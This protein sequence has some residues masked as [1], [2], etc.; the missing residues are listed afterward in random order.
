M[1]Q[2]SR[3]Q[4]VAGGVVA[5]T[6]AALGL[7]GCTSKAAS[8]SGES[9]ATAQS[10]TG[11][12]WD[13]AP[14]PIADSQISETIES[15]VVI[16]GAGWSGIMTAL[17]ATEMGL[18]V[19]IVEKR[20]TFTAR[21]GSIHAAYSKEMEAAG[22]ER[23][24][25]G[26]TMKYDFGRYDY[27]INQQLWMRWWRN[28]EE[29]MNWLIDIMAKHGMKPAI[30]ACS[31]DPVDGSNTMRTGSHAFCVDDFDLSST[32]FCVYEKQYGNGVMVPFLVQ[33]IES[34]GGVFY[35]ENTAQ[36]LEKDDSGRVVTVVAQKADGS[37]VRY[38]GKK[39]I[40]LASG[41][42]SANREMMERYCDW[43][44]PFL[45][46]N[47]AYANGIDDGQGHKM[48]LWAGGTWQPGERS[49][50]NIVQ[51]GFE[52]LYSG[53]QAYRC[54][55]GLM[56]N[57]LGQ[58]FMNEDANHSDVAAAQMYQPGYNIWPIWSDAWADVKI[59]APHKFA[60]MFVEQPELDSSFDR[61]MWEQAVTDGTLI[62]AD[63]IEEL[64]DA[65]GLPK[66][67]TLKTIERYNELCHAGKDEDFFKSSIY[68]CPIEEGPFYT[69]PNPVSTPMFYTVMGGINVNDHNQVTDKDG[70]AI[71]GLY[72][73]GI[74]IAGMFSGLYN[75]HIPGH[76]LGQ[77]LTTGYLLGRDLAN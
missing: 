30:D 58:R 25:D 50:A 21:G 61:S 8:D 59:D 33:D 53:K 45:D 76:N 27:N 43:A 70:K 18:S 14:D 42:F 31:V 16:V 68:L 47:S 26:S 40:V 54:H 72:A 73:I 51:W 46:A 32:D 22:V 77:S 39:G 19:S 12:S 63:T 38:S 7:A 44:I 60:P 35:Y 6:V 67:E 34:A 69:T 13:T 24:D 5:S 1:A 2:L 36:Q 55:E 57:S 75:W 15:D 17:S 37:Y 4:F 29:S 64:I 9:A 71:E 62:K 3:R 74:M 28:S 20:K 48:A 52:S 56:V 66:D 41:D 10:S 49:S 65:A 11:N 23:E